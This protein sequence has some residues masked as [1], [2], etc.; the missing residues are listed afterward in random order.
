MRQ[1]NGAQPRDVTVSLELAGGYQFKADFGVPGVPPLIMDEPEPLGEDA[2]PNAARVLAAAVANCLSASLLY[3]L[4]K[5]RVDVRGMH[6]EA[7]A[8]LVRNDAGRVQIRDVRVRTT[9]E[10]DESDAGRVR[11]CLDIF[12]DYCVV[13]QSVRSGLDV[14]I[15][16]DP[17]PGT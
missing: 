6:S 5:A 17:L 4:R 8:S 12:E 3:C 13:T 15:Q 9:P 16:V 2:G 11:R 10:I 7:T 14:S 1:D